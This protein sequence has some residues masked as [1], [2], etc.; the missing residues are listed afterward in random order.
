MDGAREVDGR[1]QESAV[2]LRSITYP[3]QRREGWAT[4]FLDRCGCGLHYV[5]STG[6][7]FVKSSN[8]AG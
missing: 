1:M 6:M 2:E 8:D 7:F 4:R 5:F 3:S